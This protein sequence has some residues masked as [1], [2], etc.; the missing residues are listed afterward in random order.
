MKEEKFISSSSSF[1]KI[2]ATITISLLS[3]ISKLVPSREYK[4]I[5]SPL[6]K[7]KF[8]RELFGRNKSIVHESF[9]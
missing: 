4:D 8:I 5:D 7:E 1:G 9:K 6:L 2:E 3:P